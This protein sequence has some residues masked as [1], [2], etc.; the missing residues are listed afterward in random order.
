MIKHLYLHDPSTLD[1]YILKSDEVSGPLVNYS[2]GIGGFEHHC[3]DYLLM[4]RVQIRQS[5]HT[6]LIAWA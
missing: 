4:Q 3:A 2:R 1:E 5:V 6:T